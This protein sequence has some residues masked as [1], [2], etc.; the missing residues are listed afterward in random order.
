M[1]SKSEI[2]GQQSH[3]V[4]EQV[5]SVNV[6]VSPHRIDKTCEQQWRRES[7]VK[8]SNSFITCHYK[9]QK[10]VNVAASLSDEWSFAHL[11]TRLEREVACPTWWQMLRHRCYDSYNHI[12]R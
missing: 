9:K 1:C 4:K 12:L 6:L 2:Q 5:Q 3:W 7:S 8:S 10:R 11:M